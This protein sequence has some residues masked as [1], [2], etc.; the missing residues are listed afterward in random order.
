[1]KVCFL[2]GVLAVVLFVAL[3]QAAIALVK[4]LLVVA[5]AFFALIIIFC[6]KNIDKREE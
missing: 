2:Y 6:I 4:V 5:L 3:V 1:M